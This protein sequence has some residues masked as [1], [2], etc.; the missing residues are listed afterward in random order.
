MRRGRVE[1]RKNITEFAYKTKTAS[2]KGEICLRIN[3]S[4]EGD[5]STIITALDGFSRAAEDWA[6]L[7]IAADKPAGG[8]AAATAA[9]SS[10]SF[11]APPPPAAE[12]EDSE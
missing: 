5:P 4:L 7:A 3:G 6:V 10:V 1:P 8:K 2:D 11:P 9:E 12:P